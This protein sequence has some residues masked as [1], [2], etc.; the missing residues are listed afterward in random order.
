MPYPEEPRDERHYRDFVALA[1]A[2]GLKV[3][4][5]VVLNHAG[6]VFGYDMNGNG[7][8]DL[9]ARAMSGTSP[10]SAMATATMPCGQRAALEPCQ[11]PAGWPAHP[12]RPPHRD[13]QG[14]CRSVHLRPQGRLGK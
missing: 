13:Q 9:Q 12:A 7:A 4:Q 8:F 6:P 10:S 14:A 3:V 2:K 5:D 1:H 11:D